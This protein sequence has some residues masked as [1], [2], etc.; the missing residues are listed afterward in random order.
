[1]AAPLDVDAVQALVAEVPVAEV[2]LLEDRA[3]VVRRGALTVPP[4][5]SRLVL[6]KVAPVLVDK[7]LSASLALP[8]GAEGELPEDLRVR[9]VA[10]ARRRVTREEDRP[11]D[12]AELQAT[13]RT[14]AQ[15]LASA[16]GQLERIAAEHAST[17]SL[18][19]LT[20]AEINEDVGWG[21]QDRPRWAEQLDQL[22]AKLREL[23]HEATRLEHHKRALQ[24]E[25]DD[26]AALEAASTSLGSEARAELTLEF[27]NPGASAR[28]LELSVDYLVP[29]ALW[30]PWHRARLVETEGQAARVE[31]SCEGAVWQAS[32]EDWT[33]VQ[34]IFSTERPSLGVTPPPLATDTLRVRKKTSTVEVEA[35]DQKIHT[36][37]LGGEADGARREVA[38][39]ELPGID[40]GGEAIELRGRTKATIPADGRPYRVPIF[41]FE[42]PAETALV[43]AAELA[44][45]VILRSRQSNAA[46]H[47]LLA[48]PVDLVRNSG[49]VG[50]TSLLYIAPGERFELGWGPDSSLRVHREVEELE[51]ERRMMSSWTRKPR[52]VTVKLSNLS[53]AAKSIEVKERVAVSEIEK[54]EVEVGEASHGVEADDD[55][56]VTWALELP[57]F[58]REELELNWTMLVHDDVVG[59]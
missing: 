35:R 56:F 6:T 47:P 16:T 51:H 58:G 29:G 28:E 10:V 23:G 19:A 7:T 42:A 4:G 32:G 12:L 33:D 36:A 55:G 8:A 15:A 52:R 26:L 41:D 21:R 43:C 40:D 25:L 54:V 18:L 59:L 44:A 57:G 14:K 24:R 11:V 46:D 9:S 13:R 37:G 30:R 3:L 20:L 38:E 1:M 34:L 2:T 53:P 22:E 31:F 48:G 39:S 5:R 45:S 17:E 49:L 50:R 27:N